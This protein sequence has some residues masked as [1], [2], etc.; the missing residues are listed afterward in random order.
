MER[1][2]GQ[3]MNKERLNI[4]WEKIKESDNIKNDSHKLKREKQISNYI[5]DILN[6]NAD[7]LLPA[8]DEELPLLF[9]VKRD[10]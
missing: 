10:K 6:I 1:E 2:G 7:E 4:L 5:E 9:E 3:R 8:K